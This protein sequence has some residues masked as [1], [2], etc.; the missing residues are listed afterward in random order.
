MASGWITRLS[1]GSIASERRAFPS[2][3]AADFRG[4]GAGEVAADSR[5]TGSRVRDPSVLDVGL[6]AS[7]RPVPLH[8]DVSQVLA[9]IGE[10]PRLE[11]PDVLAP[12]PRPTYQAGIG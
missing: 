4:R 8:I 7:E 6:E 9:G 2:I 3:V 5:P 11:L 10:A 12:P 1:R